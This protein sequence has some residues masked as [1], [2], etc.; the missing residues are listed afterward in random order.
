[1]AKIILDVN[2]KNIK[3]I[4]LILENLKPGLI[5]NINNAQAKPIS[6]SLDSTNKYT[7]KDKY[8]KRLN[9]NVLE[10]EFLDKNT[11]RGKYLNPS[12]YKAK[13]TKAK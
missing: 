4:M 3:T 10:D 11:S 1:M 9:N 6:S 8:K 12:S 5:N 13:L 7:S 2:D